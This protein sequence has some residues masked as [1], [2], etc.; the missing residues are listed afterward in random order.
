MLF[1]FH[2]LIAIHSN[3][4]G[5]KSSP[6]T[7]QELQTPSLGSLF[8]AFVCVIASQVKEDV[9][10]QEG[11]EGGGQEGGEGVASQERG[12]LPQFSLCTRPHNP[13]RQ[14]TSP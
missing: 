12:C 7:S 13:D 8:E 9:V 1:Y 10:S 5:L 2:F 11:A 6:K 4:D 3:A 14:N